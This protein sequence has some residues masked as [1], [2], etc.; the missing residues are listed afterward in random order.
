MGKVQRRILKLNQRRTDKV[1]GRIV[2]KESRLSKSI[3][4]IDSRDDAINYISENLDEVDWEYTKKTFDECGRVQNQLEKKFADQN[5]E[6]TF[7][8]QGS[9]T[10]GTHIRL[11]SDIDLLV[12]I[13]KFITLKAP[14]VPSSPYKGDPVND[15]LELRAVIEKTLTTSYPKAIVDVSGPKSVSIEGGSLDRKIDIVP[16][17]WYETEE[18]KNSGNKIFRG[19]IEKRPFIFKSEKA[20]AHG[21]KNLLKFIRGAFKFALEC[22]HIKRNPAPEMKFRIG[23]KIKKVL[24]EDQVRLFLNKAKEYNSEWYY[25]WC[26]AVYT[27][28]RSGE[29]YSLIWS[30]VNFE[31]RQIL[32]DTAWNNVDGFKETKSGHD[33]IVEIA[34]NLLVILK[35]LKL[36][37]LDSHFVLPRIDKW[38]KGE[39]ARELRIFLMGLGL[40]M[41]RFHD[42]R[43]T[44]V[45]IMLGRGVEVV[46]VMKLCGF[47]DMKTMMIYMRKAGVD[48]KGA[49]NALDLHNPI[50]ESAAVIAFKQPN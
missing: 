3:S 19:V 39:Q 12:T 10:N 38:D 29:L 37:N 26:A 46:K 49:T 21:Q 8:H 9:V 22:D 47:R 23:D 34:P 33:R 31:T 17:N 5:I 18:Y 32:V 16:S 14:L 13:E 25:H 43:A 50:N 30:K 15:M 44:H 36:A 4:D 1:S 7:N 20:Q 41:I 42:L 28:M 2:L 11:Y 35:E 40:P 48:V 6:A 24:T 27:G 45:T